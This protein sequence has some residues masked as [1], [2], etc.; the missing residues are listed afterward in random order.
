MSASAIEEAPLPPSSGRSPGSRAWVRFRNNRIAVLAL[1]LLALINIAAVLAP[2]LSPYPPNAV[3]LRERLQPP[4]VKHPLGTD[5]NGRDM[6]S[7]LLYG[8]RISLAVGIAAVVFAVFLGALVGGA[9]GFVEGMTDSV[10]MRV[11]DG[12]LSVPI[13]FFMIT[14]LALFGATLTNI[15]LVIGVTSWMS[16]ARIVRG[17]V[18]RNREMPFVEAARSLGAGPFHILFRHVLPQSWPAII[19]SAT[20]GIGWAILMESSLS[21]LGLGVQPP[22]SSW[23]NMLSKARGYMWNAP[24]LAFIPGF[25]IFLTVLLCNWLGDGLRDAL[26]PTGT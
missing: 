2:V 11:T 10:L 13:F 26:D 1:V 5:E 7:R 4:S 9:A 6:L 25:A 12:M 23:G 21:F 8:A 15:I 19:V 22:D 24:L 17:E 16:V 3:S 14:T 20:L 18:L